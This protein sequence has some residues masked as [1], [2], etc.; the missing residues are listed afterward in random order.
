M[1]HEDVGTRGGGAAVHVARGEKPVQG[2]RSCVCES[3]SVTFRERQMRQQED[4]WS[5]VS[6]GLAGGGGGGDSEEERES[7]G[8]F[9]RML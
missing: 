2:S 3:D 7:V 8:H 9:L 5:L 1:S 4:Q 6:W